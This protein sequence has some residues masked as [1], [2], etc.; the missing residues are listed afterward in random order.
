MQD[1]RNA[2]L[3]TGFVLAWQNTVESCCDTVWALSRVGEAV[4]AVREAEF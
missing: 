1:P 3:D 4:L 2:D